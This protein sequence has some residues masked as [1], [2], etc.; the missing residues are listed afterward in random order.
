[1]FEIQKVFF[2]SP[3]SSSAIER[4]LSL[5]LSL[6]LSL[7]FGKLLENANPSSIFEEARQASSCASI[8]NL[9]SG[10]NSVKPQTVQRDSLLLALVTRRQ[11]LLAIATGYRRAIFAAAAVKRNLTKSASR[12]NAFQCSNRESITRSAPCG[13]SLVK[14]AI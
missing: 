7:F 4:L 14:S 1:M 8:S 6:S 11:L 9:I 5:S 2:R 13:S 10:L 12:L 3:A